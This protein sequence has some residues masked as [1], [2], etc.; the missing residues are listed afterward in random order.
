MNNIFNIDMPFWE[1]RD[2]LK[3]ILSRITVNRMLP[4]AKMDDWL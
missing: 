1:K 4:L 2:S 3:Q